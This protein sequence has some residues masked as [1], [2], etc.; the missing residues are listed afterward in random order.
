MRVLS[1]LIF[2]LLVILRLLDNRNFDESAK[3]CNKWF[4]SSVGF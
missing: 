2:D 1:K 3:P 4:M